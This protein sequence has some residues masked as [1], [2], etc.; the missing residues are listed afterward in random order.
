MREKSAERYAPVI[1]R[2]V[3]SDL[4]RSR[5]GRQDRTLMARSLITD[6]LRIESPSEV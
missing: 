2:F 3:K 6:Q 4:C 1:S 5:R